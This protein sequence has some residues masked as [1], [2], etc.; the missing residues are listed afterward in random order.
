VSADDKARDILRNV[1]GASITAA[2]SATQA[3]QDFVA[4]KS[5]QIRQQSRNAKMI[6]QFVVRMGASKAGEIVGNA[7]RR[8]DTETPVQ[9][10]SIAPQAPESTPAAEPILNYSVLSA[11]QIIALL[12][13]LD[14]VEIASIQ[15]YEA[16]NRNRRTVLSAIQ[17]HLEG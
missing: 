5:P 11:P 17:A 14:N 12:P 10:S 2:Q 13:S 15:A 8:I 4:D 1:I 7:R 16:L 9:D 3:A 6:G